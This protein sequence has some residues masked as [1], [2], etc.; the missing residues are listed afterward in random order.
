MKDMSANDIYFIR[1]SFCFSSFQRRKESNVPT[2]KESA[3]ELKDK[4]EL[5]V[6][7]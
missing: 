6:I 1:F 3:I 7:A 2:T 4:K 5:T